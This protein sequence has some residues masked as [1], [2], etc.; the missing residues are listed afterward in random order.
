MELYRLTKPDEKDIIA[1]TIFVVD[2]LIPLS[3]SKIDDDKFSV[4]FYGEQ[5]ST[6]SY[7]FLKAIFHPDNNED[8]AFLIN[9]NLYIENIKKNKDKVNLYNEYMSKSSGNLFITD[10]DMIDDENKPTYFKCIATRSADSKSNKAITAELY[11]DQSMFIKINLFI[12]NFNIRNID[13]EIIFANK[14][15]NN[16][17]FET[18]HEAKLDCSSPNKPAGI[19]YSHYTLSITKSTKYKVNFISKYKPEKKLREPI[20]ANEFMDIFYNDFYI[21][22]IIY[23]YHKDRVLLVYFLYSNVTHQYKSTKILILNNDV[24][25]HTNFL[26]FDK[27]Y[28]EN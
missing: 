7:I 9:H 6:A 10:F 3:I 2:N 14:K 11:M 13:S 4:L 28:E 18:I 21:N 5:Y 16:V 8:I 17:S 20:N 23:D 22:D 12:N 1:N 26:E 15:Y 19:V 27:I 24:Y 25:I